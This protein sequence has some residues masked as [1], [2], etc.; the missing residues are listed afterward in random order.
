MA[1]NNIAKE[2]QT[3]YPDRIPVIVHYTSNKNLSKGLFKFIILKTM[4]YA[5]FMV[6]LRKRINIS[7]SEALF[8]QLENGMMLTHT[9]TLGDT[10]N[11][12][13]DHDDMLHLFLQ[14]ENTFGSKL[15][16]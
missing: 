8:L 5:H 2:I 11:T 3:K 6:V 13:K 15:F 4:S 7:S 12:Y 16:I 10:Y 9:N 14:K 1:N